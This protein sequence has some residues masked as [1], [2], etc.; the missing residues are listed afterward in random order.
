MV[1][2]V[3][4]IL[5]EIYIRTELRVVDTG[6]TKMKLATLLVS[7]SI[8]SNSIE[9]KELVWQNFLYLYNQFYVHFNLFWDL[10]QTTFLAL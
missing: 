4:L 1:F 3:G 5:I 9:F 6:G 2:L 8:P 7:N 10:S